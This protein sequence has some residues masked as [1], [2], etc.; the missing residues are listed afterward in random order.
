M[1]DLEASNFRDWL[2]AVGLLRVVSD[3]T[4][5]GTLQW[6]LDRGRYRL[7]M[8]E[9]PEEFAAEC[10]KWVLDHK[11]AW[12]FG[13]LQNVTFGPNVWRQHAALAE[14][15]EAAVW[16]ALG[17][18]AVLHR[19]GKKIQASLLEY[20]HGGGHQHWLASMRANLSGAVTREDF[21][22][23]LSGAR[24]DGMRGQICRWDYACERQHAYRASDPAKDSMAQDGT[25]NALAAIGFA[26]CPSMPTRGGLVTPLAH[27]GG[28][29]RW[30]IWTDGLRIADL[31]A[32][33]LC[34]WSWPTMQG[35]RWNS[36]KL[37]CFSRG[38]LRETSSSGPAFSH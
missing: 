31:E 6:S 28:V 29:I 10:A 37:Y 24:S 2:A 26:S 38:E 36:G 9:M 15:I 23:V 27:Q 22:R 16:C 1:L 20:G 30:P 32:A 21:V 4:P 11:A 35:R 14:G 33:M 19:D 34:D 17:S 3:L 18:D 25:L 5:A 12:E 13:G 8:S 7:Q